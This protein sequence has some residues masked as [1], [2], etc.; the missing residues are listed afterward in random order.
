MFPPRAV[1]TAK[2][3]LMRFDS[4]NNSRPVKVEAVW[5]WKTKSPDSNRPWTIIQSNNILSIPSCPCG[6]FLFCFFLA[7]K[8]IF[9]DNLFISSVTLVLI[10][11]ALYGRLEQQPFTHVDG[12]SKLTSGIFTNHFLSC[13]LWTEELSK[14]AQCVAS[15]VVQNQKMLYY[16]WH[17]S[18]QFL[19]MRSW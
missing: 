12:F 14:C 3:W 18:R 9:G 11:L 19:S 16:H 4:N 7:Q 15:P 2:G 13:W 17:K 8:K 10:T 6:G 5:H 1:L